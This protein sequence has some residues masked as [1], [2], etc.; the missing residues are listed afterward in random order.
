MTINP[1]ENNMD[2]SMSTVTWE[3]VQQLVD[4]V[5][6]CTR[7]ADHCIIR[8]N[9]LLIRLE[10]FLK[11]VQEAQDEAMS[12]PY[13]PSTSISEYSVSSDDEYLH[14]LVEDLSGTNGRKLEV[15]EADVT[16]T[17]DATVTS[18]P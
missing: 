3:D 5:N 10:K 8:M 2:S 1:L 12:E 4:S 17:K 18:H 11:E 15:Q 6:V 16:S 14:D 9:A 7:T 13:S